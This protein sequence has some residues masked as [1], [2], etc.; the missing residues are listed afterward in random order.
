MTRPTAASPAPAATRV[1]RG[2]AAAPQGDRSPEDVLR[3][4]RGLTREALEN[5]DTRAAL[6]GLELEG[7]H[8]GMFTDKIKNDV[9]GAIAITWQ[10]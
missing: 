8:F 6:K 2:Q 1:S 4:L 9:T 7:K 5:G 10:E 3:D